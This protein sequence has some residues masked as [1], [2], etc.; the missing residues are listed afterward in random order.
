MPRCGL[1]PHH[2]LG[3]LIAFVQELLPSF[4]DLT[5]LNLFLINR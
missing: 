4:R 5:L 1:N 3:P 2:A